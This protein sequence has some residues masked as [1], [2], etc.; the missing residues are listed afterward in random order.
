ML[1]AV[2]K[3]FWYQSYK[4]GSYMLDLRVT[5]LEYQTPLS[6]MPGAESD[7]GLAK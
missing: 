3:P 7:P 1:Y 4:G 5:R 6:G 2:G